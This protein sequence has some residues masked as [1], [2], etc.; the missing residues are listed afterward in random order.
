MR[1]LSFVIFL[2]GF[3]KIIRLNM[4][5]FISICI[6]LGNLDCWID[7]IMIDRPFLPNWKCRKLSLS[8]RG[9]LMFWIVM[10]RFCRKWGFVFWK[11]SSF[12]ARKLKFK[13]IIL[14]FTAWMNNSMSTSIGLSLTSISHVPLALFRVSAA[15]GVCLHWPAIDLHASEKPGRKEFWGIQIHLRLL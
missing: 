6:R 11:V 7:Q 13:T 10:H 9:R 4:L 12:F 2:L 14:N 1:R 15:Q 5:T 3:W 8:L